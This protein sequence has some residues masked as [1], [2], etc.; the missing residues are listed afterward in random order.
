MTNGTW[1]TTEIPRD[2][3][4]AHPKL[5]KILITRS[6]CVTFHKSFIDHGPRAGYAGKLDKWIW[7]AASHRAYPSDKITFQ[8]ASSSRTGN[9]AK[10]SFSFY[11]WI[12]KNLQELWEIEVLLGLFSRHYREV[13]KKSEIFILEVRG[14]TYFFAL[15]KFKEFHFDLQTVFEL[16]KLKL[17]I[18][19]KL[20]PIQ[21]LVIK[22]AIK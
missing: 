11:V 22:E 21:W 19:G 8:R 4:S 12:C 1:N 5:H 6:R 13:C 14:K 9:K 15:R 3:R 10:V 17:L 18:S 2:S 20:L 16:M 7:A